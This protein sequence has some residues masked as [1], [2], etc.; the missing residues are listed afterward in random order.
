M[1]LVQPHMLYFL[2]HFL[3]FPVSEKVPQPICLSVQ[4]GSE[5]N[6]LLAHV[7][8]W[9]CVCAMAYHTA[10]PSPISTPRWIS[11]FINAGPRRAQRL[12]ML[13]WDAN[14]WLIL[15]VVGPPFPPPRETLSP[16]LLE[17]PIKKKKKKGTAQR[18]SSS[19]KGSGAGV[20]AARDIKEVG[21]SVTSKQRAELGQS[22]GF[23]I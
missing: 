4:S 3:L 1:A 23:V 14:I 20:F 7:T 17:C 16:A 13:A 18:L 8:G 21:T 12:H 15:N 9:V 11:A 22:R 2:H 5:A 6:L 19:R 10:S